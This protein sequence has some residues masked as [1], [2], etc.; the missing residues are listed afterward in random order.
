MRSRRGGTSVA[1]THKDWLAQVET[2]GPFLALPVVKDIWPDGVERLG[3]ADDRLL[4]FKQAFATWLRE[5]DEQAIHDAERYREVV[6]QWVDTVLDGLAGWQGH[7]IRQD[8]LPA[9]LVVTSPGGQVT[10]RPS[11]AIRGRDGDIAGLI[12]VVEPRPSGLHTGGF[13]GWSATE[14]DRM[15]MLL[16]KAGVEIGVVTDGQWWALVWAADGKPTGSG[17]FNALTWQEEPL[18]RDAFLALVD[19]RR[20]RAKDPGQRLPRLFQRSELEAEEITESLGTQVRKSVELLVQ[21]FSEARIAATRRGDVDPLPDDPEDAYQAAVTVM[22]RVVFLLFAE[23]RGMLPTEQLYWQSYAVKDLLDGL[24]RRALE[25]GEEVLDESYDVWHRLLAVSEAL[26]G[27]VNYDEM[28]MPAYGG[29]LLDPARYPWLTVADERGLRLRVSDRVMLHV[30]ESVQVAHVRG[31]ARRISFRDVDVEQIGYIYK[32]LLGYTCRPVEDEAVVGLVGKDGEEAEIDV[33]TLSHIYDSTSDGK[34]FAAELLAWIKETQPGAAKSIT[35][36]KLAKLYDAEVDRAELDRLLRPIAGDDT[37][38]LEFLI[39]WGNYVRRDLR[40]IPYVAPVGGLVVAETPS[41]KNAGAHYT[42]RSL[43]EEVVLHALEP[44]VYKP[45]PLQTNDEDEWKLKSATAILNLKVADI[46]AGSGAFLVATARYLGAKVLE[47]RVAEGFIDPAADDLEAAESDAIRGVIARCVYGADINPMAVEM[48]KLS[49]WLVSMDKSKPFSFVDDKIFCGNSLLGVTSL[50]QLRYLHLYPDP[51]RMDTHLL[52]DL[53]GKIAEATRL[54][55]ELASPVEEHDPMRSTR[56]KL[57]LLVQL[58]EVVADLRLIA[59]GVIASGLPLGGKPGGQLDDAYTALTWEV[60]RAFP[61]DGSD[62]ERV[63]LQRRADLGLTPTVATDYHRW[64]PL[65]WAIEAPDVVLQRGGFDAIVGNPPFLGGKRV[66]G[67]IGVE[68]R[69]FLVHVVACGVKGNADLVAYFL[70]RACSLVTERG[71]IGLIATNT[72]AQGDTREVG[73]DRLL[74]DGLVVHRAIQS[75]K[76]PARSASLEF[77]AI[78]ASWCRGSS[79]I[80][81]VIDGQEVPLINS[82][83]EAAGRVSGIPL[84]L[85]ESQGQAFIGCIPLGAGF[86]LEDQEA[87]EWLADDSALRDVIKPI[88]NGQDL[89]SRPDQSASRSV[90]DFYRIDLATA[91][92]DYPRAL[93]RLKTRVKPERDRNPKKTYRERWWQFGENCPTLRRA[94]E[95]LDR[96]L[97]IAITSKSLMPVRVSTR[98][99]MTNATCVFTTDSFARQAMLSSSPHQLWVITHGSAMK[100]DP[101]YT[102][103]DVYETFPSLATQIDCT[104]AGEP[105]MTNGARS[106]CAA[107]SA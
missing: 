36:A 17:T 19:Q 104:R 47:A 41:R 20:F 33:A 75:D 38:L 13:D 100:T 18:V 62:G 106:C 9:D 69:E 64:Q 77:A 44:L 21:A 1:D 27:G 2:E 32:G 11:G 82:K 22:M 43:A 24:G 86:M 101:R 81:A 98:Q 56:G 30:L 50:D 88:V 4:T 42:P 84:R 35:A 89:N 90:I 96:C 37:E 25:Q 61:A 102:P 93:E 92:Q 45:G 52:V 55:K 10:L 8:E 14:I 68:F 63:G 3:D 58:R 54:R 51:K 97:V 80:P 49:L 31:E 26:H 87:K 65:H 53:D 99:I 46:A 48:C 23:E 12:R 5:Y 39:D 94:L 15:S 103:S 91:Q 66:S 105:W 28:R 73:L 29:S 79:E 71:M 57:A 40:G 83:L 74:A 72:V 78:W 67:A 7:R 6:E 34:S 70:R 76:W 60:A 85:E 59:D 107:K 16:R 95:G